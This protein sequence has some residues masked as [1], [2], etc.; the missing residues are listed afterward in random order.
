[1]KKVFTSNEYITDDEIKTDLIDIPQ[2]TSPIKT[3]IQMEI[4]LNQ[5]STCFKCCRFR[6]H[7]TSNAKKK[8]QSEL[9]YLPI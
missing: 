6:Q 3:V 9:C 7:K 2:N 1:M 5:L 8:Y 4:K